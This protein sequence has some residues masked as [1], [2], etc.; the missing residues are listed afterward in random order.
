MALFSGK[1]LGK[2]EKEKWDNWKFDAYV[3]YGDTLKWEGSENSRN[4]M[5]G[6]TSTSYNI[7]LKYAL[8]FKEVF[9]SK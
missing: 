7:Q 6:N 8:P 1:K 9:S 5:S 4:Q 3:T 2:K